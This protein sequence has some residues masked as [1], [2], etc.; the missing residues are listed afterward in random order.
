MKTRL[1]FWDEKW[2]FLSSLSL[3]RDFIASED[4]DGDDDVQSVQSISVISSLPSFPVFFFLII[5]T[6]ILWFSFSLPLRLISMSVVFH[7]LL[8]LFLRLILP[9]LL[10]FPSRP[11]LRIKLYSVLSRQMNSFVFLYPSPVPF[12]LVHDRFLWVLLLLWR[13]WHLTVYSSFSL[14]LFSGMKYSFTVRHFMSS[15]ITSWCVITFGCFAKDCICIP[16]SWLL[17]SRKKKLS[18]GSIS[19]DGGFLLYWLLLTLPSEDLLP[20]IQ[21]TVGLKRVNT[22]GFLMD[23]FACP[24]W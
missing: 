21:S 17:L 19:S 10:L 7:S 9:V 18:S 13:D 8:C 12:T 24:F 23:L 15:S 5:T 2:H 14:S 11:L 4:D 1:S 16:F 3:H 20:Q 6:E 22:H